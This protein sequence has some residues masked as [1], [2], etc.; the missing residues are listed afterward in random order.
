M[1][2]DPKKVRNKTFLLYLNQYEIEEIENHMDKTGEQRGT[3][4]REQLM[5]IVRSGSASVITPMRRSSD[6]FMAMAR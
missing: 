1:Y 6:N 4:A 2:K 5:K 3:W